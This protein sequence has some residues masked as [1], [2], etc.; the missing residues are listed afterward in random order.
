MN[1][2]FKVLVTGAT[3][4]SGGS[5]VEELLRLGFPVRAL[6]HSQDE[7]SEKLAA[8]GVE[9]VVGDL[10]RFDDMS[11]AMK[12]IDTA[13]FCFPVLTPGVLPATAYFAQAAREAGLKGIVNMSQVSARRNAKSNAAQDHWLG[14]RLL[15][16]SGVPVTHL[17]PTFFDDWF[18]YIREDIRQNNIIKLPFGKGRWAPVDSD[19]LGRVVAAILVNPGEYAGK[20]LNLYG[21]EEYDVFEM[22][23]I[24]SDVL[25]RKITYD[26]VSI[27][28]FTKADAEKGA[29][30]HFTQHV[31]HVAQDCLD[32]IFAGTND[33]VA[34]ITGQKPT[35]LA[36]FFART[37]AAFE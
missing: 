6:V 21:P 18:L 8:R 19:D 29:H 13:Y 27:Q 14:E 30:T 31:T 24:L 35:T 26:P 3:G 10:L 11:A 5:A 33:N 22:S 16:M 4:K 15:D 1:K 23:E 12:G 34:S 17:R 7:R 36:E 2:Q 28:E 32:G 37:R 20:T 9:I 25:G